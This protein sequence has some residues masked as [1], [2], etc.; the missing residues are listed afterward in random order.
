MNP[1][2]IDSKLVYDFS[3]NQLSVDNDIAVIKLPEPVSKLIPFPV[4]SSKTAF[5][6]HPL[7][8]C[9]FGSVTRDFP[10][11]PAKVLQETLMFEANASCQ[12]VFKPS[13]QICVS[14]VRGRDTC[15]GDSG[16]PLYPMKHNRPLCLY[17]I[18]SRGG[19]RC[20]G[21]GVYTR[22]SAYISWINDVIGRT[23]GQLAPSIQLE[24]LNRIRY[25]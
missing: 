23:G 14:S 24:E 25:T 2:E 1:L 21:N 20:D 19:A 9:G 8:S 10:G 16:G 6:E 7:G 15:D 13:R 22:V 4:C 12:L 5:S 17:G 3:Y 18:V 11:K